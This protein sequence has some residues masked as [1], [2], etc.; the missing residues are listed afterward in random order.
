MLRFSLL[1]GAALALAACA[2][3]TPG[4]PGA[5]LYPA[6]FTPP[7]LA[8]DPNPVSPHYAA[9]PGQPAVRYPG[10]QLA[11]SLEPSDADW[12]RYC[13]R[14]SMKMPTGRTWTWKNPKTGNGGTMTPTSERTRVATRTGSRECR[15]FRETITLKNGNSETINGRRC[16]NADG[17]WEFVG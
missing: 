11:A 17:S 9:V 3:D 6:G 8:A 7:P 16:L 13:E 1:L 5:G 2:A 14:E 12:L 4:S 15:S 10:S